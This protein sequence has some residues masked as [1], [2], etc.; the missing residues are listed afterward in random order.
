MTAP[1]VPLDP[2]QSW[3]ARSR[4]MSDLSASP[5]L[6]SRLTAAAQHQGGQLQQLL[7][8]QADV[9]ARLPHRAAAPAGLRRPHQPPHQPSSPPPPPPPPPP[10]CEEDAAGRPPALP[11]RHHARRKS[12]GM[13][14]GHLGLPQGSTLLLASPSSS[15]GS[16]LSREEDEAHLPEEFR[17][18]ARQAARH[19][20]HQPAQQQRQRQRDSAASYAGSVTS[21]PSHELEGEVAAAAAASPLQAPRARRGWL[22]G[23]GAGL[24]GAALRGFADARLER[25]YARFLGGACA[26]ADA[27]AGLLALG[28]AA[29]VFAAGVLQA[30]PGGAHP[31]AAARQQGGGALG[32]QLALLWLHMLV[33][34]PFLPLAADPA[35]FRAHREVAL[36][37]CRGALAALALGVGAGRLGAPAAWA[38][39]L[40]S[41]RAYLCARALL[42]PLLLR[43]RLVPELLAA[44]PQAGV[45]AV[46]LGRAGGLGPGVAWAASLAA[47]ALALLLAFLCEWRVSGDARMHAAGPPEHG[48]PGR[49]RHPAGVAALVGVRP[50]PAFLL[51]SSRERCRGQP[52]SPQARTAFA[53]AVRREQREQREQQRGRAARSGLA[54]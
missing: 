34:L 44:L 40:G 49:G 27:A 33:A 50:A 4:R 8:A 51:L 6:Q 43:V 18:P 5:G 41:P 48:K 21:A 36:L 22:A 45:D 14:G 7:Q 28:L 52:P 31:A 16:S 53:L 47:G 26:G 25:W 38:A 1:D 15:T 24:E 42:L 30:P 9:A 23:F 29:A 17:R 35:L 32:G 37:A 20:R 13:L 2:A 12:T 11:S 3:Q 10:P 46:V 19:R 39:A 54:G